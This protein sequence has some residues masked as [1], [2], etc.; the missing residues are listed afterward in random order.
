M[1]F[2]KD[3]SILKKLKSISDLKSVYAKKK[4]D[5]GKN[6]ELI[7]ICV[8]DNDG[9]DVQQLNKVGY[10]N[11]DVRES[12]DNIADFSKYHLILCDVDGIGAKINI[13]KQ[14]LYVADELYKSY[15]PLT[16]VAIYTGQEL[17][18]YEYSEVAGIQVIDKNIP[19]SNLIEKIDQICAVFWNPEKTWE[20]LEGY[21][22]KNG[23][24]NKE[25][26]VLENIFVQGATNTNETNI[27]QRTKVIDSSLAETIIYNGF[28]FAIMA[29]K[30][31]H[32]T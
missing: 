11:I 5:L 18:N 16:Q 14:G 2:N 22:K 25:I 12:F 13:K 7:K 17:S 6:R 10:K 30:I 4:H 19:W 15:Y 9:F 31:Y 24:S 1:C 23:L 21:F 28:K 8:L 27:L 26:A 32:E 20:L 3:K 29:F